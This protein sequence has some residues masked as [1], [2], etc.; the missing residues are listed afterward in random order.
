MTTKTSSRQKSK[1]PNS[2][3]M[4]SVMQKVLLREEKIDQEKKHF[5]LLGLGAG[6]RILFI[7]H[8]GTARLNAKKLEP[9][10]LFRLAVL[11]GAINVMLV[12]NHPDG[13]LQPTKE[14]K[15]VTDRLIQVGRILNIYV[16]DH[17]IITSTKY[18]SF[19][20]SGLL[21]EL[22]KSTKWVPK[23]EI[24]KG[25]H[26]EEKRIREQTLS[27]EKKKSIRERNL[28]IARTMINDDEP[29]EKIVRYTGLKA[30]EIAKLN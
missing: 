21:D 11:K 20:K 13:D 14:E 23:S 16:L 26:K 24:A 8:V 10:N 28:E 29:V 18:F 25:L 1:A 17:L 3:N 7:E 5:W 27:D 6:N 4:A 30:T 2:E 19:A 9:M 12:N 15:E 22:E